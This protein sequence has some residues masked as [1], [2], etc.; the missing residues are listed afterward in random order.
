MKSINSQTIHND[1]ILKLQFSENQ[2]VLVS[3]SSDKTIRVS[4]IKGNKIYQEKILH[5]HLGWVW[6]IQLLK[7]N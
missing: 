7:S 5:N 1:R 2:S 4:K 6:D 3:S